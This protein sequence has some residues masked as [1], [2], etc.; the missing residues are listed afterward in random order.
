MFP[1]A[2]GD[3]GGALLQ[4]QGN[5]DLKTMMPAQCKLI[6]APV[7]PHFNS[8]ANIKEVFR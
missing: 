2:S 6:D 4:R 3:G 5:W 8:W 7:P 1:S